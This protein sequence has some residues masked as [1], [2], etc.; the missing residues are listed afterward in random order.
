MITNRIQNPLWKVIGIS[1]FI[2]IVIITIS[3]LVSTSSKTYTI[4]DVPIVEENLI[5]DAIVGCFKI[6]PENPKTYGESLPEDF[7]DLI[8]SNIVDYLIKKNCENVL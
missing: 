7:Y 6:S 8:N 1:I 3:L 4:T 5:R 2:S